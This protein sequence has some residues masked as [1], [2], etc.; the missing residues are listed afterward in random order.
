MRKTRPDPIQNPLDSR[1]VAAAIEF[2]LKAE[3]MGILHEPVD[4]LHLNID[5]IIGAA[6][7]VVELGLGRKFVLDPERWREYEAVDLADRLKK[8]SV[9]L[10]ESPEPN[11]EWKRLRSFLPDDLLAKILHISE[12]SVRRYATGERDTPDDIAERVHWVALV[13]GDL[14]GAYNEHGVRGWFFRPRKSFGGLAPLAMLSGDDW[15]PDAKNPILIREFAK[16]LTSSF[17]T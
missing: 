16:S 13:T 3:S 14:F 17:G 5:A 8:L 6:K 12:Q 4:T 1:V 9:V 7:Q 11:S 2:I 10:E 15:T